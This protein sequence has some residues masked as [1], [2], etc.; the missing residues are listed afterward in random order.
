MSVSPACSVSSN[1]V[2][3]FAKGV[4]LYNHR[5]GK[6]RALP[7][8]GYDKTRKLSINPTRASQYYFIHVI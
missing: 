6:V 7:S 3:N 2:A 4:I 1:P 5:P 8:H